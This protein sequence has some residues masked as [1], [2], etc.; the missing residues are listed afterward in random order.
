MG[1]IR[2]LDD[3]MIHKIAAGEVVQRPASALKE[4][5][6]NSLDAGA[7]RIVVRFERMGKRLLEVEDD[8]EGMSRTDAM[9]CIERHATS[10]IREE[11]GL[12]RVMTLGFRGEALPSIAAVS[13]MVIRTRRPQD[14]EGTELSLD[15]GRIRQV[16]ACGM[17]SGTV[18]RVRDLFFNTRG[19]FF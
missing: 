19:N 16:K 5:L 13:R 18:V 14:P 7:H 15:G 1:R 11:Q 3:A 9:L 4:L 2:L 6:E 17:P 10:K 8:G 12:F